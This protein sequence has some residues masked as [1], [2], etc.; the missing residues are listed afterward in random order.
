MSSRG[1][2]IR[3]KVKFDSTTN[4]HIAATESSTAS[5]FLIEKGNCI[6]AVGAANASA[7]RSRGK[8]S[9]AQDPEDDAPLVRPVPESRHMELSNSVSDVIVSRNQVV[10]P[11]R[12]QCN[13]TI[14]IPTHNSTLDFH[15]Q[16]HR[17]H[18]NGDNLVSLRKP[19]SVGAESNQPILSLVLR[20][21]NFIVTNVSRCVICCSA[22]KLLQFVFL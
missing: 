1:R 14:Q 21:V 16:N 8:S 2:T 6:V 15:H 4:H 9:S 22:A 12:A 17:R 5:H 18:Q 13:E 3:P 11:T 19:A 20:H 10:H 7:K